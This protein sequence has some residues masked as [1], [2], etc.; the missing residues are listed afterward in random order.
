MNGVPLRRLGLALAGLIIVTTAGACSK[1]SGEGAGPAPSTTASGVSGPGTSAQGPPVKGAAKPSVGCGTPGGTS[2]LGKGAGADVTFTSGGQ[3]RVYRQFVP[4][5]Y[6]GNKPLPVVISS[7]GLTMTRAQE[8]SFSD[9]EATAD[10]QGIVVLFTQALGAVPTWK[11]DLDDNPDLT[12]IDE[13]L[14]RTEKDLCIDTSRVYADGISMGGMISSLMACKMSGKV[15]AVSLISGIR[16]PE[17][18]SPSRPVPMEVFWGR[19]DVILP[20]NGGF[21]IS[22]LSKGIVGSAPPQPPSTLAPEDGLFPPVESV[23]KKWA[24]ADGCQLTPTVQQ[25]TANVEKRTFPGCS[26]RAEVVFYV[27]ADGGHSWPGSK[28]MGELG[29]SGAVGVLGKSSTEIDATA[30]AWKFFQQFQLP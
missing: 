1:S 24:G 26:D 10:A 17:G 20:F 18:C 27:I 19:Q 2:P 28:V 25:V 8:A 13:A 11:L 21:D 7:H 22:F 29:N 23:V 4:S 9:W 12:Y 5:S 14:A 3:E 15:T 16:F 30:T 6:D